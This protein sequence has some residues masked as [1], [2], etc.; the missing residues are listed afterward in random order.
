MKTGKKLMVSFLAFVMILLLP[1]SVRAVDITVDDGDVTGAGYSAYRIFDATEAEPAEDGAPRQVA[2]TLNDKYEAVVKQVTGKTSQADIIDHVQNL[3]ADGIRTF[4]DNIY[5]AIKEAGLEADATA[6][7]N[8]FTGVAQGYYLIAENQKGEQTADEYSLVMLATA[9][10]NE[11]TVT[12]KEDQPTLEKKVGSTSDVDVEGFTWQ[13][14]ATYGLKD[15]VPFKLTAKVSKNLS[16]YKEYKFEFHDTLSKGLTFDKESVK[17]MAGDKDITKSFDIAESNGAITM[18]AANLKGVDGVTD[19]SEIVVTYS[20][21]V[22][23]NAVIGQAGNPNKA[24]IV[25]SNNPYDKDSTGETPEDKVTVFTFQVVANKTDDKDQPLSGAGF[26]LYKEVDGQYQPVGDEKTGN[27]TFTFDRL[28]VGKYKLVET[29][30]PA[31]YNKAADL[32]FTITATYE[33][34]SADPKLQ[35]LTVD[36][37]DSFTV[38]KS[39]GSLTTDIVNKSGQELPGTGGLG[40][41]MLYIVGGLAVVSAS[42]V[43]LA[44]KKDNEAK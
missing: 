42:V 28:N 38:D 24:K 12:T 13:D 19:G 5:A 39:A 17:I 34:E 7:D 10:L 33:T 4:A 16:Q 43:L 27:T 26:T 21:T 44:R 25:F 30:V 6:T 18:K 2:Y 22:N 41:T 37:A 8:K 9:G 23:E 31:G 29:T 20:A 36:P 35:T 3:D 40:R 15:V 14:A 1:L 11:L 32:E